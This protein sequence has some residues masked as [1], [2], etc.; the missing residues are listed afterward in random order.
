MCVFIVRTEI[1]TPVS[2][3]KKYLTLGKKKGKCNF[4]LKNN[5]SVY[6]LHIDEGSSSNNF[7]LNIK[8]KKIDLTDIL[9]SNIVN[10]C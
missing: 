8:E 5:I 1:N 4:A 7:T 2:F 3:F 9:F 10:Y 6:L